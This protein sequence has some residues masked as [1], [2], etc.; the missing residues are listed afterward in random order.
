MKRAVLFRFLLTMLLVFLVVLTTALYAFRSRA[1][2]ESKERAHIISELVRDTL[3]SYMVMG[4]MERREEFLTRIREIRGVEEIR[5]IR[6]DSVVK[7]FGGGR[8]FEM[9]MDEL[10]RAVLST[11]KE[12]VRLYESLGSVKY[13]VVMPYKAVPLKGIDCL[14]CHKAEPGET[15]GAIS[16]TMD[17][18]HV[19]AESI[20]V[21]S[22]LAL[23]FLLSIGGVSLFLGLFVARISS[24]IRELMDAMKSATRGSFNYEIKTDPGYEAS[25][26]KDTLKESFSSLQQ[27]L[28]SIENKVRAMIGYGVLKTGDVLSDTS[29]I[30][31]ELLNIYK[32]KR[33]IEKDRTREEIYER[34]REVF[35]DY[36]SLDMFS[37]YE[38]DPVKN[39]INTVFVRGSDGWCNPV[40][41]DNAEECRAKR[42]GTDVDSR[43]FP[44]VCPSFAD[45]EACKKGKL[46][47]YCIPVYVGG[48]VG[49]V[50]QV[51]YEP[52]IEPFINLIIPYIKGY[53]N[54]AAPVLEA[55]T[56]MDILR[57]QSLKDQLTGLHNRRFLEEALDKI[58]A[59]IKR[60]G[61]ALGILMVDVDYFKQV[62]D[63][64][65]HDVG[66]RVLKEVANLLLKSVRE[67]DIVVRY[68]GEEFMVLLVDVQVGK[69]EELAEKIRKE[70]ENHTIEAPGVV[71]KKTVSVGVSEFPVDSDKIWQ[72]IKF[73]DVALYKAKEMG[74]NRVVRFR[75]EFWREENY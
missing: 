5:V 1:L 71:L 35:E 43:E 21:F 6:G 33:V 16:L 22:L 12:E 42:T 59:Q 64:Y 56:Y 34:L 69:S 52:E 63:V 53:L 44:C 13:R 19:R 30:V 57:E 46:Y 3:T 27:T 17:L 61:T 66:D 28:T 25:L 26:L 60:R 51:V 72:C 74:R 7:Q 73:A 62:N 75:Q 38:V 31:D 68:G 18:S 24:F 11:G 32:F 39:R 50:M 67:A 8:R 14:Q 49:N 58:T 36:M 4:V 40:I 70:V 29:K 65:G 15:L 20:R 45:N 54:E 47:Y 9:P 2:E 23:V 37:L 41:F 55:R 48:A 10:E